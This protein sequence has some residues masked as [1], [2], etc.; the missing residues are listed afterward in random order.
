MTE[1]AT[2]ANSA[3]EFATT[4]RVH[5]A[6]NVTNVERSLTFYQTLFAQAPA[7]LR[8]GYAKFEVAEPPVNFT[9]NENPNIQQ[10]VGTFSHFGIQ[11]KSTAEVLAAK[12]RFIQSGL[13]T[14]SED[15]VTCCYAVQDKV[16]VTDP[17]GNNWE[18]FVVLDADAPVHSV[19]NQAE[20]A[21]NCACNTPAQ[22]A[23][24]GQT[25]PLAVKGA[26]SC[27]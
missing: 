24:Q 23:A 12:D 15:E 5:V 13:A 18:V 20:G 25:I 27:C 14:F 8:P 11:V 16:W 26:G 22:V 21:V 2:T 4:S 17:D 9:L 3:V 1:R 6:V 7:K 10:G 19:K